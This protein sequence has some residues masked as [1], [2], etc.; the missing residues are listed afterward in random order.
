MAHDAQHDALNAGA[1]PPPPAPPGIF[2]PLCAVFRRRLLAEGHK[3]TPERARI[4]DVITQAPE[5]FTPDGV[6]GLLRGQDG[7]AA[8]VSKA[9]LY[10][11]LKLLESSG[12]VQ[13]VL[14]KD[15]HAHYQLAYGRDDSAMLIRTDAPEAQSVPLPAIAAIAREACATRGL[16]VEGWR[17]V[18]YAKKA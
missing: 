3:Y 4:L 17:L 15:G 11:T 6:L 8:R 2:E 13:Q 18:I 5:P 16:D 9:T 14:L 12:I 10:R 7:A 1:R